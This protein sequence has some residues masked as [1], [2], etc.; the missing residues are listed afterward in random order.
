MRFQQKCVFLISFCLVLLPVLA[1]SA[2]AFTL[3]MLHASDLEGGVDAIENAPRFAAI[4]DAVEDEVPNTIIIS[5]GDNYLP[6]PF[7]N[8]QSDR[9]VFRDGGLFND[10]YN[11]LFQLPQIGITGTFNGLREGGG[12]VDISIMN[13]IGFDASAIGNHEFDL[14]SDTFENAIEEDFR[15]PDG[16]ASD[17]WVGAQFPYLSANLDFSGD[18]DLSNLFTASLLDSTAFATGPADSE[19]G[20]TSYPKLAAATFINVGGEKI[21]VIG[22]TTQIVETISSPSGTSVIGNPGVDDMALLATQIQPII[23][24]MINNEGINKIILTTHLQQISLE[25]ALAANLTGVDIIVAGGSDTILADAGVP[26][27]PGDT[28]VSDYPRVVP[29]MMGN[30]VLLVSTDGNYEYVGRL[31]VEFDAAGVITSVNGTASNPI[32]TIQSNIDAL[33]PAD[34]EFAA[35]SKGGEVKKLTDALTAL[36]AVQDGDVYGESDVFLEGRREFVRTEETNMGN[37]TADANLAVARIEEPGVQFSFK[38]GGGIR[39]PIGI[40]DPLTGDLLPTQA[41]PSAIPA[42][43]ANQVSQLDIASTLRFNNNLTLMTLTAA[44][45]KQILEHGVA[46]SGPGQTP[47]RFPQIAGMNFSFDTTKPVGSRVQSLT[48]VDDSGNPIDTVVRRGRIIGDAS[49]TFRGVSL[50]FLVN[51]GGDGYPFPTFPGLNP[52]NLDNATAVT[53]PDGVATFTDAGTEQDAL[54]EYFADNFPIGGP[55]FNIAETPATDDQRIQNLTIKSDTVPAGSDDFATSG[56]S[57]DG[58]FNRDDIFVIQ[59]FI[60]KDKALC[61][62]CD[63]N[64]DNVINYFDVRVAFGTLC[65]NFR[66]Q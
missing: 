50:G 33:Y 45:L 20:V 52:L 28:R 60:G 9:G 55:A 12:R 51:I 19:T 30:D 4:V 61:P 64:N 29:D 53:L 59:T 48:I 58:V 25:T 13:I 56:F 17:R 3:Q 44:E 5:A 46:E 16:P 43:L 21:G 38:N 65:T 10:I 2:S 18:N 26:L 24:D 57:K 27:Q 11:E 42:K 37:I 41:N 8:A 40:V 15:S 62:E 34:D 49:R 32:A 6:G 1:G 66:C 54:A 7:F 36:V 14:G 63:V 22:G 47:G 35:G 23:N 39:N 31:V